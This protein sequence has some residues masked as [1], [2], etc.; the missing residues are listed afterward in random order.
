MAE[1]K[2]V[3]GGKKQLKKPKGGMRNLAAIGAALVLLL[4]IVIT[5]NH[6]QIHKSCHCS[7]VL[8]IQFFN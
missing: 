3:V 1:A 4:A 7:Q 8:F 5:Y 6:A 2:A